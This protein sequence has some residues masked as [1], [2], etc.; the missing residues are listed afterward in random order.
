MPVISGHRCS[1][2]IIKNK[3]SLVRCILGSSMAMRIFC[4]KNVVCRVKAKISAVVDPKILI[5]A[6]HL[7]VRRY[8]LLFAYLLICL[9]AFAFVFRG[10]SL[11]LVF[12]LFCFT[13]V[14]NPITVAIVVRLEVWKW[15]AH[16]A[17][18]KN[19]GAGTSPSRWKIL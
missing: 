5:A 6:K 13:V 3:H 1:I 4:P 7:D 11:R 16:I 10:G 2:F 15:A 19:S 8:F 14:T 12:L 9:F 18:A 17:K